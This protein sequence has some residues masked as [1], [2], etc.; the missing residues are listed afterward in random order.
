MI[1][2]DRFTF[3]DS[4]PESTWTWTFRWR[5]CTLWRWA[6]FSSSSSTGRS[7]PTLQQPHVTVV[8]PHLDEAVAARVNDGAIVVQA[9]RAPLAGLDVRLRHS[10]GLVV[11]YVEHRPTSTTLTNQ[12]PCCA[13]PRR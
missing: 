12:D 13:R 11:E 6:P 1:T 10:D 9:K 2:S 4:T 8:L 3:M 5:L 7:T